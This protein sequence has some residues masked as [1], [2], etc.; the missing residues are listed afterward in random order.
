MES[1]P[2]PL[3][4]ILI[5]RDFRLDAAG[6]CLV[7]AV[8]HDL[9]RDPVNLVLNAPSPKNATPLTRPSADDDVF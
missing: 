4:R 9:A 2:F 8:A 3:S 7:E 6:L 1:M 5:I